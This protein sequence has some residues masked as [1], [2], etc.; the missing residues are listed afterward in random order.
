MSLAPV[1]A[2]VDF[3]ILVLLVVISPGKNTAIIVRPCRIV[4]FLWREDDT[5]RAQVFEEGRWERN[6]ASFWCDCAVPG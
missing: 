1:G 4:I 3:L 5:I 6:E 2:G